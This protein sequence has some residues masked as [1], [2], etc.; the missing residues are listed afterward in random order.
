MKI[1]PIVLSVIPLTAFSQSDVPSRPVGDG[2]RSLTL[3]QAVLSALTGNRELLT[4]KLEVEKAE[5]RVSEAVGFALPTLDLQASYTRALKKPVFYLPDFQDPASGRIT[6]IEIGSTHQFDMTLTAEQVLFNSTVFIGLGTARTY[7]DVTSELYRAKKVETVTKIRRA[8][9]AVLVSSA[10]LDMM[11]ENLENASEN[12]RN[13]QLLT[14]QGLV[15]EYD[16]LRAEV[17]LENIRPEVIKAENNHRLSLNNLKVMMGMRFEE[18]INVQ[19][20]LEFEPVDDNVL[21]SAL[22]TVLQDNPSLRALRK[23]AEV[24][25]AF[26]SVERAD[27]LPKLSAFG[28]L[29]YSAQNNM[30]R[31]SLPDFIGSSVVGLRLSMNLFRGLQTNARVEQAQIDLQQSKEMILDLENTL[32]TSVESI[33]S[34]LTRARERVE[35]QVRTVEQAE[36]G[37]HIAT[38]RFTS[39]SGT[40]LEVHDAQLALTQAKVN[41]IEAVYDYLVA[42]ADLDQVLGR[43]PAYADSKN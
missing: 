42:S 11:R 1:I 37:Y 19:G 21:Q 28:N 16:Q 35:A 6:P 23:Q 17:G 3:E 34:Q 27:Y 10:V 15:S 13:V 38:I 4:S 32:Q 7:L 40:Q 2:V 20:T 8:F 43:V 18:E 31:I 14:A 22:S 26:V 29:Q 9:Y 5:A 33:L 39:G 12:L 36:K 24:N 25:D 30:L 41:R